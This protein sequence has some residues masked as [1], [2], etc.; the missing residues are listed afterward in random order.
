MLGKSK[1]MY[2]NSLIFIALVITLFWVR[3]LLED[4]HF[5]CTSLSPHNPHFHRNF[6]TQYPGIIFLIH[7]FPIRNAVSLLDIYG[8]Q[9]Y[10]C[11]LQLDICFYLLNMHTLPVDNHALQLEMHSFQL[12]IS[13]L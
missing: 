11:A 4:N 2:M 5:I 10:M 8:L 13:V 1:L 9:L 3:Y 6:H 7:Y 12:A